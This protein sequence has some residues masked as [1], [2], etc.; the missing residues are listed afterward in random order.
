MTTLGNRLMA[1]GSMGVTTVLGATVR[2]AVGATVGVTVLEM[3]MS[4]VQAFTLN[5]TSGSWSNV[6]GGTSIGIYTVGAEQQVRW[7]S[8]AVGSGV[9]NQSGLGFTGTGTQ[10]IDI[11]DVFNLGQ[12]RHFNNPIYA[13]TAALTSDLA[14][15][16][17][18]ADFADQAFNFTL[19]IDE[20]PNQ[21]GTCVYPSTIPCADRIT[22]SNAI[23]ASTVSLGDT[24]Y[25]LQ[26]IGFSS[27][28]DGSSAV[29]NFISQEQGT[30]SAY[31][32]G[33]LTAVTNM[34]N[35]SGTAGIPEP[36]TIVGLS[37]AGMA[38]AARRLSRSKN[39]R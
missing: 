13:G 17:D 24:D 34:T 14:V 4:P 30:S 5:S 29:T 21:A 16:L 38:V 35:V 23:S 12:L 10:T 37:L 26:L 3:W 11:G 6:V 7:G 39:H 33:K 25:T 20:T 19:T 18:F 31:L 2:V 15:T 28:P 36:S 22:W 9:T 8:P 1:R 27:T 32:F